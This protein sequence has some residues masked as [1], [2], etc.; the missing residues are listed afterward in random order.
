MIYDFLIIGSG[1]AAT[2]LTERLLEKDRSA[3]ILILEA[4]RRVKTKDFALWQEHLVRDTLPY[5]D[6]KDLKYPDDPRNPDKDEENRSSGETEVDLRHSRL[7]VY[8]GSTMAWGGYSLRL[9][10]EDFLLHSNTGKGADWPFGYDVLEEYY[11]QAERHLAVSGNSSDTTVRRS[12]RYPFPHFPYT[13]EDKP[14]ADAMDRLRITF[15]NMPI[16][17]RGYSD[18]PSRHAPCHTTG[19]CDYCPFGAKYV[20]TNYL[21]DMRSWTDCPRLEVRLNAVV[22]TIKTSSKTRAVS[23]TYTDRTTHK[24]IS[25]EA[26]RII[27]AAG[28]I[29]SAKLLQRSKPTEW[30]NG[31]G[32][33][34][35]HV[36]ANFVTHP[37]VIFNSPAHPN[38]DKLQPELDFPTLI[39]RHFDTKDE[40]EAG[41]FV[42]INPPNHV[43]VNLAA[44]FKKGKTREAIDAYVGKP[45]LRALWCYVE[46]FGKNTN[47]ISNL[48]DRRNTF[49]MLETEVNFSYRAME[50][51]VNEIAR[52]I[53]QIYDAM[54]IREPQNLTRTIKWGAHHAASTCRMSV[55][56]RDGVVDADLKVHGMENLYVCSNAV[57]PSIGAVNPTLTLTAL[58]LRLGDHLNGNRVR[59]DA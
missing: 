29:E 58:A 28:A 38:R 48:D 49:K 30:P 47:R 36:G 23:V 1:V 45:F 43:N 32:N 8:G 35:G 19:T 39:S 21:D 17:R 56:P 24:S 25:A 11:C 20:A 27:I 50:D 34:S 40:Q 52:V 59:N 51:R 41:K 55:D 42:I 37:L 9:R 14:V 26:E 13:F 22:E 16:A 5:N 46:V 6:C 2:A 12:A 10:P 54:G 57:F 53:A 3:S 4:G 33:D 44:H 31:I 7:F 18:V 15:G